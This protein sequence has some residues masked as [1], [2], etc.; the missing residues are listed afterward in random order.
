LERYD[1]D[2]LRFYLTVNATETR[3]SDFSW[4]EFVRRNNDELVAKWG[5]FVNRVL[6]F[7]H[8]NFN[9]RIP[10]HGA[11]P[12]EDNELLAK[13]DEAFEKVGALIAARRFK[14]SIR[15]LMAL[16]DTANVWIDKAA[17]WMAIKTDRA[18]A[19][20]SL[21][22]AI[23]AMS[24]MKTMAVPYMPTTSQACHELLG[25]SGKA[26]DGRW[27]RDEVPAGAPFPKPKPLFKKLDE[28]LV[29]D[30]IERLKKQG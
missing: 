14:D 27:R 19:S 26:A 16:W 10:D 8:K 29:A 3:D 12:P 28:S 1:P 17:P 20:T 13:V 4:S 24:G 23:Q 2:P 18:K 11:L 22:T 5:N 30:E 7:T 15:E 21:W 6:S 9:G 25:L